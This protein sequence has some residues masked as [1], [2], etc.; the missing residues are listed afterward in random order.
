ME[1]ITIIA[2]M[3]LSL[4]GYSSGVSIK[5]SKSL[6][7]KPHILDLFLVG[8]IWS[9]ALYCKLTTDVNRWLLILIWCGTALVLGIFSRFLWRR[10]SGEIIIGEKFK[11]TPESHLKKI[12]FKWQLFALRMGSF[13][14]RII[15]A[16]FFF[17]F[18]TPFAL[19]I[20]IF[21]D[22]LR[23]KDRNLDTH[24]IKRIESKFNLE[25][26]RRQF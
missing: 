15:L 6:V 17:L 5:T 4:V 16:V 11:K 12:W 26:F 13:Q 7:L 21:S 10:E 3:L 19:M 14:G 24:W 1:T 23:I 22:P 2:L 8:L 9:G 18:V 20:R 25:L